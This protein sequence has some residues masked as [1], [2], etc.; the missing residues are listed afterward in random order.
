MDEAA[1]AVRVVA[2]A[3]GAKETVDVDGAAEARA[4]AFL[5]TN[6]E[7]AAFH[8]DRLKTRAM[9]FD[10]ETRDRFLAGALLPAAWLIQAQRV[11]RWFHDKMMDLFQDVDLVIAPA[12]PCLAPLVG[13][14][15]IAPA[16]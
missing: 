14:H 8:L 15:D 13:Q 11:R 3:L 10:P 9:D 5:I 7:S 2:Q 12:T 6:G 4:A 1:E 16:R